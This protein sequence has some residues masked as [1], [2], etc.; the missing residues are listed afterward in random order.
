MDSAT[1]SAPPWPPTPIPR[2]NPRLIAR[3]EA[4]PDQTYASEATFDIKPEVRDHKFVEDTWPNLAP[5][6][7]EPK[8]ELDPRQGLDEEDDDSLEDHFVAKV[9]GCRLASASSSA[10][11]VELTDIPPKS[12]GPATTPR[13]RGRPKGSR[14]CQQDLVVDPEA[15]QEVSTPRKFASAHDNMALQ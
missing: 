14:N 6:K 1:Q 3:K 4:S 5:V 10:Q 9:A 13:Q 8:V 11:S 2:H 7:F 12:L 15:P